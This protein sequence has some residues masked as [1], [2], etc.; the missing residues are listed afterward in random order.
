MVPAI[1]GTQFSMR[2]PGAAAT[3]PAEANN[4][5]APPPALAGAGPSHTTR[6]SGGSARIPAAALEGLDAADRAAVS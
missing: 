6:G 2:V 5:A 4:W 3:S 1:A